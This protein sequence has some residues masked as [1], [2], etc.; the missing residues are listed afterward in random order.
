MRNRSLRTD[1]RPCKACGLMKAGTDFYPSTALCKPC[2]KDRDAARSDRTGIRRN[3]TESARAR[4]RRWSARH[5]L[6]DRDIARRKT[7]AAIAAG[8]LVRPKTC[9]E[10][11]QPSSRADGCT[12]IHA[13]HDDYSQPLSV[14]WLCVK[15]HSAWHKVNV[16]ARAATSGSEG[17]GRG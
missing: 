2:I 6:D 1:D 16:A 12:A 15:C 11:K 9:Q 5:E 7:M 13:H 3:D 10:C 4:K 14:R 17:E 8:R